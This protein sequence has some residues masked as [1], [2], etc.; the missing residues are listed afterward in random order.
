MNDKIEAELVEF[1]DEIEKNF[2]KSEINRSY[3]FKRLP[4]E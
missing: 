2:W 4:H 1:K 3:V